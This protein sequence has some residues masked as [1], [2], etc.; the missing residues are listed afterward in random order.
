MGLGERAK[1]TSGEK[2]VEKIGLFSLRGLHTRPA[3]PMS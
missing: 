1:R 3:T 2:T